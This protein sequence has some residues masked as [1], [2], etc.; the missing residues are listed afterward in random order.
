MTKITPREFEE[1]AREHVPYVG[2]LGPRVTRLDAGEVEVR[3]PFHDDFLRP[4]GTVSGPVLMGLADLAMYAM[5]LS[6]VGRVE[7]AVTTNLTCNFLR[8]PQPAAVI[9]KGR[10]LKLGKRL[11]VGEVALYSDGDS[12]M[13]AHV[14][15][16]YSIP[17]WHEA[18]NATPAP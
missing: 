3:L 16:T 7:L 18:G 10:I 14:T 6:L 12:E 8:R 4:G 1:L 2:T 17:P 11:A 5:V 9:A 15:A 13:V